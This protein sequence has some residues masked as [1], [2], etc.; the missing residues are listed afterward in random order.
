MNLVLQLLLSGC[1]CWEVGVVVVDDIVLLELIL[2]Q[3]IMN[4]VLQ[5]LLSGCG[6]WEVGVVVVDADEVVEDKPIVPW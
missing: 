4:L 6:C 1:G 2:P 5:L 3:P